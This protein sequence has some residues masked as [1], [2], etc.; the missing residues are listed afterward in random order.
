MFRRREEGFGSLGYSDASAKLADE[1]VGETV[2][3]PTWLYP[4]HTDA[5]RPLRTRRAQNI[6]TRRSLPHERSHIRTW[7]SSAHHS[8]FAC[9]SR[10]VH[11][12]IYGCIC[13]EACFSFESPLTVWAGPYMYPH[14]AAN[15]TDPKS[16]TMAPYDTIL[17][18][19]YD[20][21]APY[22]L[23]AGDRGTPVA[24]RHAAHHL[25]KPRRSVTAATGGDRKI[26]RPFLPPAASTLSPTPRHR[27]CPQRAGAA[28]ASTARRR[29]ALRAAGGCWAA[30]A[31]G[32]A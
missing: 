2:P 6:R 8:F 3:E 27:E 5:V 25:A 20:D 29:W 21:A 12:R 14:A 24:L 10:G 4:R 19:R 28:P 23:P 15:S 18:G 26:K 7:L 11:I 22:L 32:G 1:Q 31:A 16:D 9:R 17:R 13:S 30:G